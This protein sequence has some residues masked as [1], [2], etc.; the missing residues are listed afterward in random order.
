MQQH[1]SQALTNFKRRISF[2][3][4]TKQTN[5]KSKLC[6][7]PVAHLHYRWGKAHLRPKAMRSLQPLNVFTQV[8][9]NARK[10]LLKVLS[11]TASN[12]WV[13]C[14]VVP[15]TWSTGEFL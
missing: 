6:Q 9:P 15:R 8:V 11:K 2:M 7:A 14:P 13:H 12:E 3:K 10:Q 5:K 4:K 1:F